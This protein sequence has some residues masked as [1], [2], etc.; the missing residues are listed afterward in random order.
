M[1][2][3]KLLR[4]NRLPILQQLRLEEALLRADQGNWCV[5]NDGTPDTSVV[6][7]ISGKVSSLV[8]AKEAKRDN[9]PVIKRFSGGGTVVVDQDT[10][11]ATLIL[12]SAAVPSVPCFPGHIMD[13]SETFYKHAFRET[14]EYAL[15][16]NDYVLGERKFGGNAQSITKNRW[17]HHTSFL[18]DFPE[19]NMAYLKHPPKAPKYR[20]GRAHGEFLTTLK[21]H[22]DSRENFLQG[23]E[24]CLE[25]SGFVPH[26]VE[27]KDAQQLLSYEY[28]KS[29]KLVDL[30]E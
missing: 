10:I 6:M 14:A 8:N 27:L 9:I 16:E 30:E 23:L 26:K 11:F 25:V 28:L 17:L 24:D 1:N 21:Q 3:V 18:W 20:Q 29:T 15:R 4:V 13:W 19:K 2:V 22:L 7:G 5:I 12:N